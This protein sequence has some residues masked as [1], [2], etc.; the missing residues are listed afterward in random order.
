V[1]EWRERHGLSLRQL[2]PLLGVAA[3]TIH[4]WEQ[5]ISPVPAWLELALE[6]LDGRLRRQHEAEGGQQS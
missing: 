4:R 1:R 3:Y 2:A 5:G 6:G